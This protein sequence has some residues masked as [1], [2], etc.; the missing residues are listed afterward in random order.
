MWNCIDT[1]KGFGGTL[2]ARLDIAHQTWLKN[3][4]ADRERA[5]WEYT[6]ICRQIL[7]EIR[8]ATP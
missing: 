4:S 7:S 6:K 8:K 1:S 3:K 2:K 5:D